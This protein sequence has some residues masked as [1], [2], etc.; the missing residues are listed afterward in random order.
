MTHVAPSLVFAV[1]TLKHLIVLSFNFARQCNDRDLQPCEA[2]VDLR[3]LMATEREKNKKE[4]DEE[5]TG[6]KVYLLHA[7]PYKSQLSQNCSS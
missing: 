1:L 3:V 4:R 2:G 7:I 6:W 5:T